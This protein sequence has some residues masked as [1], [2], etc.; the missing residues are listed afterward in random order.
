MLS[1]LQLTISPIDGSIYAERELASGKQIEE[2][3]AKAVSSQKAWKR[4]PIAE[5][6]AACRRMLEWLLE[7]ADKIGEELTWQIGRP[8]TYSPNEIRRGFQERVNYMAEIAERELSD[9]LIE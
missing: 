1:K 8:I 3:L 6:V 2:T 5:R 4:T 9:I 7:R